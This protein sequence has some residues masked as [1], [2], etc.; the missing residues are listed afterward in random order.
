MALVK[1]LDKVSPGSVDWKK[2]EK[3]PNNKFKK[4]ANCNLAVN[5]ARD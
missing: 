4:M 1:V 3:N 2:V 5:I